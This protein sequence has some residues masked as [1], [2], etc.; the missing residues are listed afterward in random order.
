MNP[1]NGIQRPSS[2]KRILF[3]VAGT[4]CLGL[5]ALGIILPLLP[6]TPFLLLTA[7]CYMRGSDRMYQWLLNNKWFGTYIR[8]YREGKGIPLRGKISALVLLWTTISFTA[9]FIISIGVIRVTLFI[10]AAIVS[11]YLIRLPTLEKS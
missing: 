5:G 2:P 10:I 6:T 9:I 8:N 1:N 11:I 7:A 4:I 3:I